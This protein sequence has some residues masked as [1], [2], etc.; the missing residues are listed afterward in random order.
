VAHTFEIR[1]RFADLDP[2]DHVN[3]A[4]YFSYF[5]AARVEMLEEIGFGMTEMKAAGIQ[6]V[7]VRLSAGFSA[8]ATLHDRLVIT[9]RLVEVKRATSVWRQEAHRGDQLIAELDVTAAFTGPDGRPV[10]A[11]EE[12]VEA[13]EGYR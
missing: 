3:H 7:L 1:V 8:P 11:P 12:F 2:Y 4:R 9:T 13:A 5:E 6:I 10:R